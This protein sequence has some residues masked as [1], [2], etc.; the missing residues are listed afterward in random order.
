MT[1]TLLTATC[2]PL[3][4][5]VGHPRN[6]AETPHHR[7]CAGGEAGKGFA[8]VANEVKERAQETAR[9]GTWAAGSRKEP[10]D[11]RPARW[12]CERPEVKPVM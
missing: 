10:I 5:N 1:S 3:T 7:G 9:P 2:D 8:A 6:V 4:G 11:R 12:H